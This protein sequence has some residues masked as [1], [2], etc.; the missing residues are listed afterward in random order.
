MKVPP[1][2]PLEQTSLAAS[3]AQIQGPTLND[4]PSSSSFLPKRAFFNKNI[5]SKKTIR[6]KVPESPNPVLGEISSGFPNLGGARKRHR[7]FESYSKFTE[8]YIRKYQISIGTLDKAF[9]TFREDKKSQIQ[10][11]TPIVDE[12]EKFNQLLKMAGRHL[13][14]LKEEM[15]ESFDILKTVRIFR[16]PCSYRLFPA[17][18]SIAL[19]ETSLKEDSC[20]PGFRIYIHSSLKIRS[21]SHDFQFITD[22]F[23]VFYPNDTAMTVFYLAIHIPSNRRV[24]IFYKFKGKVPITAQNMLKYYQRNESLSKPIEEQRKLFSLVSAPASPRLGSQGSDSQDDGDQEFNLF[25]TQVP[26]L[27]LELPEAPKSPKNTFVQSNKMGI[28]KF[29]EEKYDR[30][31]FNSALVD[32]RTEM[33]RE[34]KEK[35][36]REKKENNFSMLKRQQVLKKLVFPIDC[37]SKNEKGW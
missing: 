8:S 2:D 16:V 25:Q 31:L 5:K 32:E 19:N 24:R 6:F 28:Q 15:P 23:D 9:C 1:Y 30:I 34:K 27:S 3:G 12:Q 4:Y 14:T 11:Q 22:N 20:F 17:S 36:L 21:D 7:S 35:L 10:P 18:F 26:Y 13:V 37:S 29:Q 33:A